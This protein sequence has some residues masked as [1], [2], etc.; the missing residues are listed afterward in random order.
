METTE[1]RFQKLVEK[2]KVT[3][4]Y[5]KG[6]EFGNRLENGSRIRRFIIT[7]F[8]IDDFGNFG[9]VVFDRTKHNNF[10]IQERDLRTI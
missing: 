8:C 7:D 5:N 10:C 3:F 9:Y 4:K 1:K 2:F 6:K